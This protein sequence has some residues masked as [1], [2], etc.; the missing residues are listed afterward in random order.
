MNFNVGD[1]VVSLINDGSGLKK[2]DTGTIVKLREG[3][4]PIIEW[5]DFLECRHE[6]GGY[7]KDGHGWFIYSIKAIAHAKPNDLGEFSVGEQSVDSFLFSM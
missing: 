6:A 3:S 1:K 7:V 4:T 5:D 2:G